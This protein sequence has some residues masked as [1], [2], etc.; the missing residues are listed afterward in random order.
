MF[1]SIN[2]KNKEGNRIFGVFGESNIIYEM[3]V[4]VTSSASKNT[5]PKNIR[6]F[7]S[8]IYEGVNKNL[9]LK[10]FLS[11]SLSLSLSLFADPPERF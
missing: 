11:L 3:K 10:D 5:L 1:E 9:L 8:Y 2:F 6:I 4:A 7:I